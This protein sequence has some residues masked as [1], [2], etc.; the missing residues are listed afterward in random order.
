MITLWVV[1]QFTCEVSR[2][3]TIGFHKLELIAGHATCDDHLPYNNRLAVFCPTVK[4]I[5]FEQVMHWDC[6]LSHPTKKV[7]NEFLWLSRQ[8]T[9]VTLRWWTKF[10]IQKWGLIVLV[11][12]CS[13]KVCGA[14][15]A[16]LNER[17]ELWWLGVENRWQVQ[18]ERRHVLWMDLTL[19]GKGLL[20][21]C[22]IIIVNCSLTMSNRHF[23]E[24]GICRFL[25]CWS[26]VV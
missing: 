8:K 19:I 6:K 26:R 9:Q 2:T 1:Y 7:W 16:P 11:W 24:S 10:S 17:G 15:V 20:Q 22:M 12:L 3:Y 23:V 4:S 25:N 5:I 21:V 13:I 14:N 18:P